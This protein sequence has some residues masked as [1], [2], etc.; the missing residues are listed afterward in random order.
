MLTQHFCTAPQCS[1]SRASIITS[2]MP[3]TNG[4]I[5]LAHRGFRL[6]PEA[7]TLPSLLADAGYS[8]NLLGLQ[9]EGPDAND[10]G[11]E[12]VIRAEGKGHS[13]L[14][15]TPLVVD[16]LQSQPQ[17]PFFASVGF[18][19]THRAY[20]ESDTPVED[21]EPFGYL[22]DDPAVRRDI[23]DLEVLVRRV[24]DAVG[25]IM[26]TLR[27]TGLLDRTLVI[28][29]TDHGIAFPRAKATL[30]D[31][32]LGTAFVA[33]LPEGNPAGLKIHAPV[34]NMD[35]MPTLLEYLQIPGPAG[36][37]GKSLMEVI[38]GQAASTRDALFFE[39]TYHA[40]Y[41][42]MRAVRTNRYK[43]IRSFAKRPFAFPPNVDAGHTKE[44]VN[45]LGWFEQPR[46]AEQLYD[47]AEDPFELENLAAS[48]EHE[49]VLAELR[50]RLDRWME[51]TDD[52]LRHG[53]VPPPEGAY[54]TPEDSY[55]P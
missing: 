6:K 34:S 11:Y 28:F 17:E 19:E 45:R 10:L 25:S 29:T 37:H 30:F 9:H 41:D 8:T 40:A 1:P 23:A 38:A 39:L 51:E 33:R 18:S 13:C 54:V 20:P 2:Q 21:V 24:D 32:G 36:I 35:F 22:P 50:E 55:K 15:V 47:L 16:F 52:P 4:M 3:H 14:S 42:P 31:P 48:A 53:P 5:G 7:R 12:N 27:A 49:K 44:L 46:P 43:Y 26:K